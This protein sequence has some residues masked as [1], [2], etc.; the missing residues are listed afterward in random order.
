MRIE[1]TVLGDAQPAGSKRAFIPKGWKRAIVTDANP[2]AKPWKQQVASVGRDA[3]KRSGGAVLLESPLRLELTIYRT[4]PKSHFRK[5]GSIS[6]SAPLWPTTKPDA[7]KC[8]RAIEDA[9][10]GQLWRDDSHICEQVVRKVYGEPAR[11][12]VAVEEIGCS[13]VSE[14]SEQFARSRMTTARE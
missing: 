8:L 7:T 9:L 4:R 3:F 10:T 13:T 11:V 6:P 5:N 1:F 12:E 2:K 14:L